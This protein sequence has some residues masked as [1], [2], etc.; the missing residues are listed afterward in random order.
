MSQQFA[1]KYQ[2]ILTE[3]W[4]TGFSEPIRVDDGSMQ[5]SVKASNIVGDA[6][7][8]SETEIDEALELARQ[9]HPSAEKVKL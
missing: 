6:K 1:I 8:F 9:C 2:G 4:V 5:R 7:V 3:M